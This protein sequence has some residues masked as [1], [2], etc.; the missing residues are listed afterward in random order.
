MRLPH[1]L[2]WLALAAVLP[3]PWAP[4][5]VW[6][7]NDVQANT[8]IDSSG[9]GLDAFLVSTSPDTVD[10]VKVLNFSN[11]GYALAPTTGDGWNAL[12]L[13]AEVY[14][15]Q[16]GYGWM[17]VI[18]RYNA[19]D[20]DNAVFGLLHYWH[21]Q[22]WK[23][24]LRTANGHVMLSTPTRTGWNYLGLT[25]DGAQLKLY[26]N[27]ER[28]S[29]KPLTGLIASQPEIPLVIGNYSSKAS[30][31]SFAGRVAYAA[32]YNTAQ[33]DEFFAA[34]WRALLNQRSNL[35]FVFAEANDCHVNDTKSIEVVNDGV[36]GI[37]A[38]PDIKFSL[39]AGDLTF[40]SEPLEMNLIYLGLNR[41]T[42]A[43]YTIPGNHELVAGVYETYFG[44]RS[45][46]F[47]YGRWKF[48]MLD[49]A[50]EGI[51]PLPDSRL[52]WLRDRI[53]ETDPNDPIVLC[54]HVPLS[55]SYQPPY[56]L[57]NADAVL[58]LFQGY[59]LKA[60]VS[61]HYH[62]NRKE[63]VNGV[64]FTTTATLSTTRENYDGTTARG[65]REF[66]CYDD[67]DIATIFVKVR[68]YPAVPSTPPSPPLPLPPPGDMRGDLNGDDVINLIDLTILQST[69]LDHK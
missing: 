47:N 1:A 48:I 25:Y 62:A 50:T 14:L 65:Y 8:W 17:G 39:W 29:T 57:P 68:D 69:W 21:N 38:N 42:R 33:P 45:Y 26:L 7:A 4:A 28:V 35:N 37:N 31:T 2:T 56:R 58:A 20:Y 13:Y 41:L 10:G 6:D 55:P 23:G 64:L 61:G 40:A 51:G 30:W 18:S 24:D 66:Y 54:T 9:E 49:D 44:P 16:T 5:A 43:R 60:V 19:S 52:N 59:N 12:T 11:G 67:N 32:L 34:R 22:V 46:T 63:V 3:A 36:D 27:G 15:V 53:A